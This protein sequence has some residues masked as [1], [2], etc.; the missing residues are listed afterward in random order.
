MT[1]WLNPSTNIAVTNFNSILASR[2]PRHVVLPEKKK[3][4]NLSYSTESTMGKIRTS[5]PANIAKWY[6]SRLLSGW[7]KFP[8][9]GVYFWV[10]MDITKR[11][12]NVGASRYSFV[13]DV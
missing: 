5:S 3:E 8:G 11:I 7:V 10:K 2:V 4:I 9:I 1:E 12:D 6:V 13:V